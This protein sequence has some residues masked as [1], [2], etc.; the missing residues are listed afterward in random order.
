MSNI[1]EFLR[2]RLDEDE[3]L[4]RAA[5][6]RESGEWFMGD[7]WNVYQQK[8]VAPYE[9]SDTEELVVYGN[10]K[11]QSEHIARHD[12]ARVLREVKA[13]RRTLGRHRR[14][15]EVFPGS[16]AG[17]PDSCVGCGYTGDLEEPRT[18]R[19]DECPEL[20]DMASAYDDHPDYNPAWSVG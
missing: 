8:E 6:D 9:Y 5:C 7:K 15:A 19:I 1:V 2:V 16:Y 18:D 4:A 14:H 20:R 10:M 12:P 3:A 13:K 11:E 17:M